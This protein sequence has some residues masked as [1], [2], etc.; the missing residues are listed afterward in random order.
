MS[1]SARLFL[2]GDSS[3]RFSVVVMTDNRAVPFITI[4]DGVSCAVNI[5]G[6][7]D[8]LNE[9]ADLIRARMTEFLD[10][11]TADDCERDYRSCG[12]VTIQVDGIDPLIRP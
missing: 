9:L 1:A 3:V 6:T 12:G 10:G 7:V 11:M 2:E 8:Q 4:T 5:F